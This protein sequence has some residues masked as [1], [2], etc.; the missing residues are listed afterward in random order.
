VRPFLRLPPLMRVV[1]ILALLCA[2]AG[3]VLVVEAFLTMLSSFPHWLMGST[4]IAMNLS[5]LGF[6]CTIVVRTY[7][8]RFR[9][10]DDRPYLLDSWQSQVR[11]LV[12]V[13]TVPLGAL[14]LAVVIPPTQPAFEIALIVSMLAAIVVVAALFWMPLV[15]AIGWPLNRQ[16]PR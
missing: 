15:V 13:A 9:W 5:M 8:M 2:L 3:M 4:T 7:S 1:D 6:A 16:S 10:P 12:I 11:A 14:V